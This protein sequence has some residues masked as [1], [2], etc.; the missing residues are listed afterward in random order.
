M[1]SGEE[2]TLGMSPRSSTMGPQ[3]GE[4]ASPYHL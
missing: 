4:Q 1:T 3:A 2:P